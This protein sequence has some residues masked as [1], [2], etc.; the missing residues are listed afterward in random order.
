LIDIS[1]NRGRG[2]FNQNQAAHNVQSEV[3]AKAKETT[4][5]EARV[6][7]G[8]IFKVEETIKEEAIF[9]GKEIIIKVEDNIKI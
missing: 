1:R 8:V 6:Q 5:I 9:K 2:N 4:L 3:K 7:G